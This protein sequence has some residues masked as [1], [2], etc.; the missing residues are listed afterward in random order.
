ML[1]RARF[2]FNLFVLVCKLRSSK[3]VGLKLCG[4]FCESRHLALSQ[5]ESRHLTVVFTCTHTQHTHTADLVH[6]TEQGVIES[7]CFN[8]YSDD[9]T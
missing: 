8:H 1:Q 4:V 7:Q 3:G 2:S 5:C 9:L 6:E